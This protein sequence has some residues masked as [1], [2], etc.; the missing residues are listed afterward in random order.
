VDVLERGQLLTDPDQAVAFVAATRVDALAIAMG[1][2]HG[3]YK[4]SRRPDG[5]TLA[6]SVV[7]ATVRFTGALRPGARPSV[8][9]PTSIHAWTRSLLV[10]RAFGIFAHLRNA[11]FC[12]ASSPENSVSPFAAPVGASPAVRD[13]RTFGRTEARPPARRALWGSAFLALRSIS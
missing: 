13:A 7:R 8:G 3:A 1:T 12:S 9:F 6:M 4:F 11:S 2:S 10:R 5:Q